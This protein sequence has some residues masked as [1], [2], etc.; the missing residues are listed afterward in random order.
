MGEKSLRAE[1]AKGATTQPHSPVR[2]A[3]A[4]QAWYFYNGGAKNTSISAYAV[5][6]VLALP[7]LLEA[8]SS[9]T[10]PHCDDW[11]SSSARSPLRPLLYAIYVGLL[12]APA[13]EW[14]IRLQSSR[15]TRQGGHCSPS[16]NATTRP[17]GAYRANAGQ[18]G[19]EEGGQKQSNA[20]GVWVSRRNIC[21]LAKMYVHFYQLSKAASGPVLRHIAVSR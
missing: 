15:R 20:V 16:A 3:R 7:D 18:Q 21:R 19:N 12:P 6:G 5:A 4:V 14:F 11:N 13:S 10:D 8:W 17:T 9:L 2:G 1:G